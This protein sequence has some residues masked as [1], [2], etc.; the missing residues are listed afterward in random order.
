MQISSP[1]SLLIY[2]GSFL[3]PEETASVFGTS[4]KPVSSN[5]MPVLAALFE[6][7]DLPL[8]AAPKVSLSYELTTY[9]VKNSISICTPLSSGLSFSISLLSWNGDGRSTAGYFCVKPTY[10]STWD[11]DDEQA[12]FFVTTVYGM[13][14]SDTSLRFVNSRPFY[15]PAKRR[16]HMNAGRQTCILNRTLIL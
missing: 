7:Y 11:F 3:F 4:I 1:Q 2:A 8:P 15:A 6:T 14:Y 16:I 13:T 10:S 5:S 9:T 12:G